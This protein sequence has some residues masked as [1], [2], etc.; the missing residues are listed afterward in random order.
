[1]SAQSISRSH[2]FAL[3]R[4]Y[5][6]TFISSRGISSTG[7]VIGY[8]VT[9][10]CSDVVL[11]QSEIGFTPTQWLLFDFERESAINQRSGL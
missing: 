8:S 1:M 6:P 10:M 3:V 5:P 9:S 11:V 4:C 7:A 2:S